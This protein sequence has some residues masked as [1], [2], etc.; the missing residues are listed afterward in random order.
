MSREFK[1]THRREGNRVWPMIQGSPKRVL[2]IGCGNGDALANAGIQQTAVGID[3]DL[4]ALTAGLKLFPGCH[5]C[6]AAGEALPFQDASF[7]VVLSRVA[8]PYMDIPAVLKESARV[9]RP[10]GHIWLVLHRLSFVTA[11][12]LRELRIMNVKGIAFCG[13]VTMNGLLLHFLGKTFRYPLNLHR[14]ESFQTENGIRR[15]L[16]Q[17]GFEEIAVAE[18]TPFVMTARKSGDLSAA[19]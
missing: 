7:D 14:R 8:M 9:L 3:F 12:F 6:Q 15:T 2:D 17:T 5:F 4:N 10:G 13:Y 19:E 11:R 1:V 16:S 18:L